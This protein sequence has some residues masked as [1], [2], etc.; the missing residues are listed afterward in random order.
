M[1]DRRSQQRHASKDRVCITVLPA[2]ADGSDSETFYC[3][4]EDLSANGLQFRGNVPFREG[5]ILDM[6]IVRG[7]AYWGF[8]FKGRVAWVRKNAEGPDCSFGIEF[9]EMSQET[10]L[11]WIETI[12]R[13]RISSQS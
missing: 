5:Q 13:E 6:L 3:T 4:T 7:W 9:S 12:E 2:T 11:A 10:R 8:Q 1:E